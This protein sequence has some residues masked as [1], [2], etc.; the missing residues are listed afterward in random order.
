MPAA[1]KNA[2]ED[3]RREMDVISA[4]LN[5]C[6]TVGS[7]S[8]QSSVL[9]AV[10]CRWASDNNEYKMSHTR[11]TTELL[12]KDGISRERRRDGIVITG[13]SIQEFYRNQ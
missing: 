6:C 11:F 12:K 4:F 2:V 7:G 5:A 8:E 13:L 9:Y 10:Y 3:Y 1:V